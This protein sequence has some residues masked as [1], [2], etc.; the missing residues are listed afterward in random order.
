ML[1]CVKGKGIGAE[2]EGK[3][4]YISHNNLFAQHRDVKFLRDW[5]TNGISLPG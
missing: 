3:I 4:S 2:A 5:L 1:L